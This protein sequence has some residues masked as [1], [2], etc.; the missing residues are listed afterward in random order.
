MEKSPLRPDYAVY[1]RA[2]RVVETLRENGHQAYFA[3]GAVRDLLLGDTPQDIDIAT[4]AR[5]EQVAKLF[6][7]TVPV[8]ANFGVVLVLIAD[9]SF[10]VATFR[11]D[12]PYVD[13][14]RPVSVH[15]SSPK[16]DVHRRDFTINGL[17]YDPVSEEILDYVE[18]R[19]DLAAGVIRCIG[20]PEKRFAEDHLRLLRAIRFSARFDFHIADATWTALVQHAATV[21]TVSPER[22]R[23]ELLKILCGR[24][25]QRAFVLLAEST[26]LDHILPEIARLQG[27]CQPPRHHPEGDVY[28]HL[29]Q[30]LA[31]LDELHAAHGTPPSATLAA[32]VLLH[33]VGKADTT[34]RDADGRIH[35]SGHARVGAETARRVVRRLR[36]SKRQI[37]R[38]VTLVDKHM[39]PLCA[40]KMKTATLKK[41]L[42]KPYFE[43]LLEL[44]R[45]DCLGGAGDLSTWRYLREQKER[46]PPQTLRPPRL[47]TG[48]DILAMGYP[49]GPSIGKALAALE[50]AQLEGQI[51]DPAAARKLVRSLLGPPRQGAQ[52]ER[53]SE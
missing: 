38:I 33:D 7:R 35:Q 40:P 47:L 27:V 24:R 29:L 21:Q 20:D 28:T 37:E 23:D 53:S 5:P 51:H 46:L 11:A 42:R 17:L 19:R 45:I 2:R 16:E 31:V 34:R 25:P 30:C 8:G 50:E 36:F 26:V 49:P 44:H 22:V 43:E 14:R 18:G 41:L 32:A 3:G 48:H 9:T 13:G 1:H 12:G 15:F 6:Q 52:D 4:S 10:E 39:Q